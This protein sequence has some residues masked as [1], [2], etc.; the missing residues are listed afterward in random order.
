MIILH[1]VGFDLE[2]NLM[3]QHALG[4]TIELDFMGLHRPKHIIK[5][6]LISLNIFYKV[7]VIGLGLDEVSRF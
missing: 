2:L 3:H 1:L 5:P 7:Q 6:N 4:L